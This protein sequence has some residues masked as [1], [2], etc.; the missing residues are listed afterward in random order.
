MTRLQDLRLLSDATAKHFGI[1]ETDK[2]W[3][4]PSP[5][6]S[7]R[8]H[9]AYPD[10]EGSSPKFWW[11]PGGAPGADL[12]YNLEAVRGAAMFYL[13]EGEPDV[14]TMHEVSLQAVSFM[15]GAG[16]MPSDKA[17]QQLYE[18]MTGAREIRIVYDNDEAGVKAAQQL[19]KLLLEHGFDAHVHQVPQAAGKDVSDIW[20]D[21]KADG[22]LFAAVIADMDEW[23]PAPPWEG[24]TVPLNEWLAQGSPKIEWVIEGLFA[25]RSVVMVAAPYASGKSWFIAEACIAVASGRRM[26]GHFEVADRGITLLCDQDSGED[27]QR[28]RYTNLLAGAALKN[29][30]LAGIRVAYFRGID[31]MNDEWFDRIKE[32]VQQLDVKLVVFDVMASFHFL[33]EN[34]AQDMTA[35]MRRL[36]EI[37]RLGPCVVI[38]HHMGK[39]KEGV[40]GGN[41]IRGSTGIPAGTDAALSIT[42]G[43]SDTQNFEQEFTAKWVKPPRFG[44]PPPPFKFK[45]SGPEEGPNWVRYEGEAGEDDSLIEQAEEIVIELLGQNISMKSGTLEQSVIN[46]LG[47]ARRT[48]SVALSRL[49]KSGT[50]ARPGRGIYVLTRARPALDDGGGDD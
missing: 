5:H 7:Y 14:W 45:V 15:A 31:L 17:L 3:V 35:F 1:K 44:P 19:R 42:K 48:A 23:T 40:T 47:C 39:P 30:D 4:Y 2:G 43:P 28:R 27:D 24:W 16:T 33:N 38:L 9:K 36:R 8:R 20:V 49:L 29:G 13:C 26:L 34:S 12:V 6:S 50:I 37:A 10:A 22:T 46:A 18:A 41:L 11:H 21:V 25:K 32:T